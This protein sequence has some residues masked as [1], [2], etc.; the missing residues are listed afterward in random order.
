MNG[1]S[2]CKLLKQIRR[3]IAEQ[4]D[5]HY[6]TSECKYQGKCSGTC[7][8]CEAEVRYLE[9][10]LAKRRKAG[11]AVAIAGIAAAL[12]VTGTGCSPKDLSDPAENT[13]T[14]HYDDVAGVPMWPED[15]WMGEPVS[16][17]SEELVL[18]GDIPDP[19]G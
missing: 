1:K 6:V 15:Q 19:E 13:A 2:K 14:D 7:P 10:E 12:L 8:K 5:I 17:Y 11:K 18:Q 9:A 3:Q 4:N 16:E